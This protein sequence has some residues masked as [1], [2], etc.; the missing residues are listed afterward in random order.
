M[1][2]QEQS[3]QTQTDKTVIKLLQ[4]RDGRDSRDGVQGIKGDVGQHGEK[5]DQGKT[6]EKGEPAGGVAYVRWG[7]DS[8]PSTGAQLVYS[9][10]AG[11]ADHQ[12]K[13]GGTNPQCLPLD[14]NYLKYIPGKQ[15]YSLMYG[16]EYQFINGIV[17]NSDYTDIPCAVCYVPTRTTLYMMPAK[18]TCPSNWTTEYY[19]Y[20]MA[21]RNHP[22][23]YRSQYT[24]IDE[25][26]KPIVASKHAHGGLLLNLVEGRCGSLPCPPYEETKELTCAV[27]TK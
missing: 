11:G 10:R 24:C 15:S 12:Q 27:C 6:G 14:P 9:G 26:L 8:C 18:Y 1:K 3:S 22:V 16:A 17:P 23:H 5:G 21:E 7:H 25:S 2:R 4:G 13:G 20:L 19:G